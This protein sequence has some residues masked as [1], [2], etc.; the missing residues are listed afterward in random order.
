MTSL[1][2]RC[3]CSL[4]RLSDCSISDQ[5]CVALIEA[6]KS[7]SSS[8]LKEL[9]L[10]YSKIGTSGVKNLSSLL[11]DQHCKLEKL[12]LEGCSITE[13]GCADLFKALKSN[14][15]SNLKHLNLN[16][17]NPGK[18]V[19]ELSDLLKDSSCKLDILHSLPHALYY[20][21]MFQFY[22][23]NKCVTVWLSDCRIKGEDCATLFEALKSNPA[24]LI[25]LNLSYNKPGKSG[26]KRLS[27]LLQD[28]NCKLEKL[29]LEWC[30]ITDELC[31]A[32]ITALKLNPSHLRELN[33]NNNYVGI[34]GVK[35]LS[36]LLMKPDCT[37][38]KLE[39]YDCRITDEDC[40]ALFRALKSNTSPCLRELNLNNNYPGDSGVKELSDL[41]RSSNCKLEKLELEW[42]GITEQGCADL[43]QALKS[44]PSSLLRELNLNRNKPGD[45]GVKVLCDLLKD[46]N[47]KLEKLQLVDCRITDEGCADLSKARKSK[48][49]SPM[50]EL[51]L[52]YSKPKDS[53]AL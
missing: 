36:G 12:Q 15:S 8:L 41:L 51:N 46:P 16:T 44:N 37:L 14:S 47:C 18:S 4:C 43:F 29:E 26:V 52:N 34:S 19:K 20:C 33:L 39:L 27:E 50:T 13:E 2:L 48:P 25:E 11:N 53:R 10:G 28:R 17:N 5:G 42:G 22:S 38:E 23:A 21:L 35:E 30:S 24:H 1:S 32:L 9:D 7:N 40:A 3:L 45:S 49:S 6:L 31:A